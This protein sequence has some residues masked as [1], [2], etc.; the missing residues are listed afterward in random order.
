MTPY[1]VELMGVYTQAFEMAGTVACL[2]CVVLGMQF[3]KAVA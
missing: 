1:E 2:L 3:V